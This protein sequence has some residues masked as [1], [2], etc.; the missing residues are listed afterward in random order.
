[1]GPRRG[2]AL[3]GRR[4]RLGCGVLLALLVGLYLGHP[5]LLAGAARFLD[6][7]EPP[8]PTDYVLV[9]GGGSDTRPFV[10]AA[11]VNRG[12]ARQVLVPRVKPYAEVE[13][14]DRPSEE[15]ITCGVL[16]ARGVPE[17]AIILLD[18]ACASTRDEAAALARF[19]DGQP[20]MTVA[21]VTTDYHTRRARA[22]F[23]KVLGERAAGLHFVA[24][25]SDGYDAG[26]WWRFEDGF[27]AYSNEYVK[28][29]LTPLRE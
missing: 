10:A 24:A 7:S 11:L 2:S 21:V 23:R 5:W 15:T 22:I 13:Q 16:R 1:M 28:L 20:G 18:G 14:G 26:N 12:L 6:V 3:K 17:D 29:A 19:L 27:V 9:L 4:W 8:Q 25:P